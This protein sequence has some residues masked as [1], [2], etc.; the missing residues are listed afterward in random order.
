MEKAFTGEK[1]KVSKTHHVTRQGV[2]KK[3]PVM[4]KKHLQEFTRFYG[5]SLEKV[6][7]ESFEEEVETIAELDCDKS[8][9]YILYIGVEGAILTAPYLESPNTILVDYDLAVTDVKDAER[10]M[11][12]LESK[13]YDVDKN[14]TY[15]GR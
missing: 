12:F 2:V 11:K 9:A 7:R 14:Q 3:N 10:F 5:G 13:G 8:K 4:F 6:T 15:R 1:M